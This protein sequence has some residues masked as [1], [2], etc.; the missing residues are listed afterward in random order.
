[1]VKN[2]T[3]EEQQFETLLKTASL[4]TI[5]QQLIQLGN[6]L[7]VTVKLKKDGEINL[8]HFFHKPRLKELIVT[9][10]NIPVKTIVKKTTKRATLEDINTDT[11]TRTTQQLQSD[12]NDIV[13]SVRVPVSV[14]IEQLLTRLKTA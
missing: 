5:D 12:E 3:A 7:G 13:I 14:F 10:R 6:K 11:I 4:K 1:M 2:L 8:T 9:T